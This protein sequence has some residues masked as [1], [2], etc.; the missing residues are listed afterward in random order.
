MS[1]CTCGTCEAI[2]ADR[3]NRG[4][5]QIIDA[6]NDDPECFKCGEPITDLNDVRIITVRVEGDPVEVWCHADHASP[7]WRAG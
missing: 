7:D 2:R 1:D 6:A 5:Q 3:L 4:V